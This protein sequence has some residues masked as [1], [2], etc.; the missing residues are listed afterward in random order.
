VHTVAA[1][2][3]LLAPT[4]TRRLIEEH[5]RRPR[6]HGGVPEELAPLTERE[7]V[8]FD[9]IA[10]GASNAEIA[11]QL[12]V[13]LATVK[14]HVNRLIAKLDGRTRVQLVVLAYECG[15]VTPGPQPAQPLGSDA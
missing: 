10:A 3:A 9:L 6:P 7:L 8:V 15:R 11:D 4:L 1:G 14:T 2:E 5:V 13:S 12:V